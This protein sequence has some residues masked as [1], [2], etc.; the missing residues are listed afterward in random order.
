MTQYKTTGP[1]GSPA[2]LWTGCATLDNFFTHKTSFVHSSST[3]FR[4]SEG[5]IPCLLCSLQHTS[6]LSDVLGCH[7]RFTSWTVN[8][9]EMHK[10]LF[11]VI[12]FTNTFF[13]WN[14]WE[15]YK[16][17]TFIILSTQY[18]SQKQILVLRSRTTFPKPVRIPRTA[19]VLS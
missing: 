2:L 14:C 10:I 16:D 8:E 5:D 11:A 7:S 3:D 17:N 9:W 1:D 18:A 15:V 19:F 13:W 4:I 6:Y 12:W